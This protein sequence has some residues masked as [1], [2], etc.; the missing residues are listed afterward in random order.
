MRKLSEIG[1]IF[2]G[3]AMAGMGLLTIYYRDFPYMLLPPN[4]S[5]IPGHL[6]L[7][8]VAGTVLVLAGTCIAFKIKVKTI[9]LLLGT[10]LLLIVCFYHIPY[11]FMTDSNYRHIGEWEN[12]EKDLALA[13]GALVIAGCFPEKNENLI[14]RSL[15]WLIPPG[16]IFFSLMMIIFGIYHFLFT[17][18]ASTL[19][20]SWLPSHIFWTYLGG[21]ALIGSGLTIILNIKRGLM[22][23]LLGTMIFIWFIILHMPRV[24]AAPAAELGDEMTSAFL[25]LAYSGIAFVIAGAKVKTD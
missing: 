1:R 11:E 9:S 16:I 23:A 15:N 22:A 6:M 17:K 3:L 8:Y 2:F 20:P 12:A 10:L 18:E 25:A 24:I 4:H 13:G 21:I 7:V 19:V 5:G 14:T